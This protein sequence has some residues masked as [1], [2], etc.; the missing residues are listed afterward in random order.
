MLTRRGFVAAGLAAAQVPELCRKSA[1]ELRALLRA[2]KVSARE[3]LDAHWKRI[4]QVNPKVNAIVTLV[5]D[6]ARAAAATADEAAA[7]GRFLGVLHGLPVAHKDL[8]DTKG[9]RTTYGSPIFKD[10]VPASSTLAVERIQGAGAICIGKTNVP[11]FGAGSQTFNPVFGATRNPFDLTKTCGGS[12]GGAA[13]ALATR[14]LPIADGSDTGGSL[15]NPAAFCSVTGFRSSPGRV[16]RWPTGG[17]WNTISVTGP[18]GRSVAD[19]ALL[20]SAMAGPD[21]RV[22]LSI[23]EPGSLF[24]RP[25]DRDFRTAR[26]AWSP[27]FANLPYAKSVLEV[28]EKRRSIIPGRTE[29]A[30]FD[31]EDGGETFKVYRALSFYQQHEAKVQRHRTLI[32]DTVIQEVEA[33]ARITGPQIAEAEA[34]RSKMYARFGQFMAQYDFLVLPVTQVPPF[35]IDQPFVTEIEGTKM[36]SYIDWMK[37]CW[38]ITITGHPA[39]SVP[40]GFTA[41]GLPIGLQIVGRHNDDWG[42]LQFAHAFEKARGPLAEPIL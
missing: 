41:D 29:D 26:I 10:H 12:S 20:L 1:V 16:P 35:S 39:I 30:Q 14:M 3:V 24:A 9:I 7:K 2:K 28:I 15:R 31:F 32:K 5:E 8:Q 42:V 27:R 36:D 6:R 19:T 33:G 37:S 18:L 40:A 21:P 25:L 17:S 22:P 11:E 4:E 13:V 23:H 38:Y 34:K